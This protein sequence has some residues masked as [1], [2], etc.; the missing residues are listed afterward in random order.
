MMWFMVPN[1][2]ELKFKVIFQ[3]YRITHIL[4]NNKDLII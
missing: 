2:N 1:I 4:G 3:N